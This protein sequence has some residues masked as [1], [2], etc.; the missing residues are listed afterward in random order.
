MAEAFNLTNT[1][2]IRYFNTNYAAADFCTGT[3]SDLNVPGCSSGVPGSP[4]PLYRENSPNS[5]Y[6]SPSAVFNPRQLQLALR[7]TW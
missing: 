2:N 5:A 7:F 6:G 1:V 4:L 3:D